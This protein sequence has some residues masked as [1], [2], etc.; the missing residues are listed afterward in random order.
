MAE[1]RRMGSGGLFSAFFLAG[2]ST[3]FPH[4]VIRLHRP[5]WRADTFSYRAAA[6]P[7]RPLCHCGLTVGSK[8]LGGFILMKIPPPHSLCGPTL[9]RPCFSPQIVLGILAC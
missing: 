5:F 4:S 8:P 7:A 1:W 6:P 9:A 3:V 2:S